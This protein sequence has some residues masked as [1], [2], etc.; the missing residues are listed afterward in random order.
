MPMETLQQ[1]SALYIP[2]GAC[3]IT[4]GCQ[5]LHGD[6]ECWGRLAK[7]LTFQR[8]QQAAHAHAPLS[9]NTEKS[10]LQLEGQNVLLTFPSP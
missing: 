1:L 4:T 2:Q 5:G 6:R 10:L 8:A 9:A 3:P 7:G